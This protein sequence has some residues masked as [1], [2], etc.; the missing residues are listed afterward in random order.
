MYL[1]Q[2]SSSH[3]SSNLI[4][5]LLLFAFLQGGSKN[6]DGIVFIGYIDLFI[7]CNELLIWHWFNCL[8][9]GLSYEKSIQILDNLVNLSVSQ[10]FDPISF[11]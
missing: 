9:Y 7:W 3:K 1:N 4:C 5:N 8:K 10:L 6:I 2:N 11:L